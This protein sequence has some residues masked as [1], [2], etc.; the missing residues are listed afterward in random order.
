MKPFLDENFL[1]ETKTAEELYHNYAAKMPV[2]DYHNHLSPGDIA[3]NRSFNNLTQ[4]WLE[5]DHY[6]WRA[7]RTAGVDEQYIT[8]N[9]SD[10]DKFIKKQYQP[11][12]Q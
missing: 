9:A 5:G 1:L 10:Q 2:I 3:T 4:A 12:K 7:M 6:K 8:G 11:K